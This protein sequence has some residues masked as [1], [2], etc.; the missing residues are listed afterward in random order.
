MVGPPSDRKDQ[1]VFIL[2]KHSKKFSTPLLIAFWCYT[3]YAY[4]VG[5]VGQKAYST[6]TPNTVFKQDSSK[7]QNFSNISEAQF[8]RRPF[9]AK[10]DAI[11][12]KPL[13]AEVAFSFSRH[14]APTRTFLFHTPSILSNHLRSPPLI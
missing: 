14:E 12:F 7:F 6:E 13:E 8:K 3:W 1:V 10:G 2:K 9:I 5:A 11:D 4:S